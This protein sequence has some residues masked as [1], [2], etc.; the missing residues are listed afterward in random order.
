MDAFKDEFRFFRQ[1]GNNTKTVQT[2]KSSSQLDSANG[3][4]G[5]N[6]SR[7]R[8]IAAIN[9]EPIGFRMSLKNIKAARD[10]DGYDKI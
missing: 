6:G 4:N 7:S 8:S 3:S 9:N 10:D 1:F 5:S 2:R